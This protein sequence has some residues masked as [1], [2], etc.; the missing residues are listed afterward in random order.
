M[1]DDAKKKEF[2]KLIKDSE[3]PVTLA[4]YQK[5]NELFG[6][7]N[8]LF[9]M[10]F[11]TR[12][13]NAVDYEYN[14]EDCY[15]TISKPYPVQEAEFLLSNQM[16][17]PSPIVQGSNGEK[18]SINYETI[19]NNYVPKLKSLQNFV[20]DQ[21]NIRA[22]LLNKIKDTINDK[23]IEQSKMGFAKL[24]YEEY[25]NGKIKWEK[26]KNDKYN[27]CKKDSN[28][29]EYTRWLSSEGLVKDEE[30]NNL[31]NDAIVRGFYHEVLTLLGFLNVSSPAET[32]EI[33]KQKMR[34]S[35]R[36]SLDGSSDIYPVSFQPS[37]WFNALKPNLSPKDLLSS[38]EK[39]LEEYSS[40]KKNLAKLKSELSLLSAETVDPEELRRLEV[41]KK[42][43]ENEY[44]KNEV[45]MMKQYGSNAVNA[46]KAAL[47]IYKNVDDAKQGLK[48]DKTLISMFGEI[49]DTVVDDTGKMFDKQQ[50][51]LSSI[52]EYTDLSRKYAE[53]QSKDY[54]FQI[55]KYNQQIQL[56]ENDIDY[57]EPLITGV[58]KAENDKE[59]EGKELISEREVPDDFMDIIMT[60]STIESM[61]QEASENSASS[62]S[63]KTGFWIFSANRSSSSSKSSESKANK[64]FSSSV[65]IGL[66]AKKISIERGGWFNPAIFKMSKEFY[67]LSTNIKSNTDLTKEKAL[68]YFEGNEKIP[69][70]GILPAFTTGFVV[71]KDITIKIKSE[72]TSSEI[73]ND[74][75]NSKSAT[76][77]G[78]FCFGC[79]TSNSAESK[80]KSAFTSSD[81]NYVYIRIPG[82]QILGWFLEFT[83]FDESQE[84]DRL[85]PD[86][87]DDADKVSNLQMNSYSNS[88]EDNIAFKDEVDEILQTLI[89]D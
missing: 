22:W 81:E 64:D 34:I 28:L 45:D 20:L 9:S 2:E 23:E 43:K 84:Y 21:K 39:L 52:Q 35:K 77:G 54:T 69:N 53:A 29:E 17:D 12:G 58:V 70:S 82:P 87:Y 8:Q 6:T 36:R 76:S 85:D 47:D 24:L 59:V 79:S 33:T 63:W 83:E 42:E 44:H 89:K 27:K 32:L 75:M 1:P 11:P 18:L 51:L 67:A 46:F 56:L 80:S 5:L 14:I 25:L 71:A 13:L 10:E 74:Y 48:T 4:L 62:S 19:V 31:Y 60:S 7:G 41:A 55:S 68:K 50:Q 16:F 49:A 88:V 40:K 65:E 78:I 57:L 38:K 37:N 30:I 15:S 3:A 73:A 72:N 61:N 66:R 86:Y 26:E